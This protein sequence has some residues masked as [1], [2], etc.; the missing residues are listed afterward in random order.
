MFILRLL[1]DT[2]KILCLALALVKSYQIMSLNSL[3]HV[4]FEPCDKLSLNVISALLPKMCAALTQHK[5][6]PY[7]SKATD[8]I[9]NK[10]TPFLHST[11]WCI[12]LYFLLQILS[13]SN[14]H[15]KHICSRLTCQPTIFSPTLVGSSTS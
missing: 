12:C 7:T 9:C 10:Y 1:I 13:S 8:I 2:N 4:T 14:V 5:C 11:L 15:S 6:I 3:I